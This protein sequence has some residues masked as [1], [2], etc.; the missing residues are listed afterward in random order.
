MDVGLGL[1]STHL[2]THSG[3]RSLDLPPLCCCLPRCLARLLLPCPSS[4]FLGGCN[5]KHPCNR[6]LSMWVWG[7]DSPPHHSGCRSLDL[8]PLPCCCLPRCLARLLLP[9]PRFASSSFLGGCN[10]KQPCNRKLSMWVWGWDS[11]PHPQPQQLQIPGPF[12]SSLLLP[13]QVPGSFAPSLSPFCLPVLPGCYRKHRHLDPRISGKGLAMGRIHN[14]SVSEHGGAL[15]FRVRTRTSAVRISA[16]PVIPSASWSVR[17]P[18]YLGRVA[19]R[20]RSPL[21][22]WARHRLYITT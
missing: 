3:C 11:P 5:R 14:T 17:S 19:P 13:P 18:L 12:T 2:H 8:L 7:W 20:G 22:C 15:S 1:T 21:S 10:R 6:K 16:L 9:C 4:S